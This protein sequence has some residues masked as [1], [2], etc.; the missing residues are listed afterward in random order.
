MGFIRFFLVLGSGSGFSVFYI[1]LPSYIGFHW[2]LPSFTRF[3]L[4]TMV[5]TGFD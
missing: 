3:S 2:V 4:V 1:V 5:F